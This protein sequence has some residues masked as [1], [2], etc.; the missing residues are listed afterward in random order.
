MYIRV[1]PS[2][3]LYNIFLKYYGKEVIAKD[4]L[5]G[6]IT[7]MYA[8]RELER[9]AG[10]IIYPIFTQTS[11]IFQDELEVTLNTDT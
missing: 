3:D 8:V 7:E 11:S 1:V 9:L 4:L 2:E 5:E 6:C 10:S